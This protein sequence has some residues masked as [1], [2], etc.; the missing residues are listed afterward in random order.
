M[1]IGLHTGLVG[2]VDEMSVIVEDT[3]SRNREFQAEHR[4]RMEYFKAL[5]APIVLIDYEEMLSKMTV[6]EY[7]VYLQEEED[8][9]KQIKLEYAKNHPIQK[10]IVDEIYARE[11]KL[12]YNSMT[13]RVNF[14]IDLDPISFMGEEDY[15]NEL[16]DT[17][18][19]HAEEIYRERYEYEYIS[20]AEC[21]ND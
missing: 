10:S 11:S 3:L 5:G 2:R 1:P 14:I 9:I 12:P 15:K 6:A 4:N 13:Y 8:E 21:K 17:F 19:K 7:K 16:Y 18:L 20:V